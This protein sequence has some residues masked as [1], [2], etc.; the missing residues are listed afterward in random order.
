MKLVLFKNE[1]SSKKILFYIFELFFHIKSL[2][3]IL[4]IEC[5]TIYIFQNKIYII[6]STI[7]ISHIIF[8]LTLGLFCVTM[9]LSMWISNTAAT[10][11]MLPIVEIVLLELEA[12][13][14]IPTSKYV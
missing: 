8:R 4:V 6:Y 10:T 5:Y 7:F 2:L 12:V 3:I 1:V 14:V 13:S 9:F 11:M